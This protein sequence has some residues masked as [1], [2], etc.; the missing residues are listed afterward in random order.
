MKHSKKYVST[1]L[2]KKVGKYLVEK[3]KYGRR[4]YQVQYLKDHHLSGRAQEHFRNNH[5]A[6]TVMQLYAAVRI[7]L[8]NVS[9]DWERLLLLCHFLDLLEQSFV[10]S[11]SDVTVHP[12]PGGLKKTVRQKMLSVACYDFEGVIKD[13]GKWRRR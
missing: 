7:L 10:D 12:F 11:F 4:K 3:D 1:K 13:V 5:G 2:I 8:I 6:L 9:S